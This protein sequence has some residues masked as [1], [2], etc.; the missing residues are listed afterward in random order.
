M[1]TSV[2]EQRNRGQRSPRRQGGPGDGCGQYE[3]QLWALRDIKILWTR[4]IMLLCFG[5]IPKEPFSAHYVFKYL[6]KFLYLKGGFQRSM[7]KT[8]TC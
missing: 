8:R 3:I 2:A 5:L 4:I 1:L 7:N 6:F